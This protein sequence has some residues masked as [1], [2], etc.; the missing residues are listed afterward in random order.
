MQCALN[1]MLK[2][3]CKVKPIFFKDAFRVPTNSAP[4]GGNI[5]VII[6]ERGM[7]SLSH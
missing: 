4:R 6:L 1:Y 2:L 7:V 3:L 5:A